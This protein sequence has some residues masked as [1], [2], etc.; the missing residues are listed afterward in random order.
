M[1][2]NNKKPRCYRDFLDGR[3]SKTSL[4]LTFGIIAILESYIKA[5]AGLQALAMQEPVTPAFAVS[6]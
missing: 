3:G 1:F 5:N 2:L 6:L 4:E